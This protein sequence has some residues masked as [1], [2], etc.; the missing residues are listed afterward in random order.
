MKTF[1]ISFTLL[2]IK[3]SVYSQQTK[4]ISSDYENSFKSPIIILKGDT[5]ISNCDTLFIMN[6]TRYSFYKQLHKQLLYDTLNVC[7]EIIK[8]WEK[9]LQQQKV[10]Y[11]KLLDNINKN[12]KL[13]EELLKETKTEI[14]K[15]QKTLQNIENGLDQSIKNLE[16][17]NRLISHKD[18]KEKFKNKVKFGIGILVGI[19]FGLLIG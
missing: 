6:K 8:S 2:F 13:T 10:I 18:K 1:I 15:T 3:F 5:V 7:K 4:I 16:K 19:G 11:E 17:A 14:L 12:D 9:D